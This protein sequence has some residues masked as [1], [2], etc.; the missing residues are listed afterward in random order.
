MHIYIY[1]HKKYYRLTRNK[2]LIGYL[3]L[4][5]MLHLCDIITCVQFFFL[6]SVLMKTVLWMCVCVCARH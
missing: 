6:H 1:C 2:H 3:T 5:T 4:L